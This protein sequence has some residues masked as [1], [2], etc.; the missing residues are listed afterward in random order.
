L[1]DLCDREEIAIRQAKVFVNRIAGKMRR[2]E[3]AVL[4]QAG[5]QRVGHG[6]RDGAFAIAENLAQPGA[7]LLVDHFYKLIF[8]CIP[9]VMNW[10]T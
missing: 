7:F 4:Q 6:R 10:I 3:A 5:E 1:G 8:Y 2:R 9:S